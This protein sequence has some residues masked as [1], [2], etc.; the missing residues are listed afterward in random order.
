MVLPLLNNFYN[1]HTCTYVCIE[2]YQN[3]DQTRTGLEGSTLFY[4]LHSFK[5][6]LIATIQQHLNFIM[7]ELICTY[8][9]YALALIF[10][11]INT[12]TFVLLQIYRHSLIHRTCMC[13]YHMQILQQFKRIVTGKS[14][15]EN[16]LNS[17]YKLYQMNYGYN[18]ESLGN[19]ERSLA[20]IM[21]N[22]HLMIKQLNI[23]YKLVMCHM[24]AVLDVIDLQY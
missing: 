3:N 20:M 5:L 6:T 11:I 19:K 16:P 21:Q 15:P 22:K 2:S 1:V 23:L 13:T 18:C 24:L 14:Q 4:D 10:K 17:T 8:Y 12:H 7:N 9:Y